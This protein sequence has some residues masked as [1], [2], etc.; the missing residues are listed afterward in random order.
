MQPASPSLPAVDKR[1]W[2]SLWLTI[3]FFIVAFGLVTNIGSS[4]LQRRL[5][6]VLA[7][8]SMAL[9]QDYGGIPLA[10]TEGAELDMN[11]AIEVH[12]AD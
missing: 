11:H 1:P 6:Q 10:M 5:S 12:L 4:S 3:H 9:H 7:P 8:Y 2:I